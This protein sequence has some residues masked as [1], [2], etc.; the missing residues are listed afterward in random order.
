M[1]RAVV[2]RLDWNW[3]GRKSICRGDCLAYRSV[4]ANWK[5]AGFMLVMAELLLNY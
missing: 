5:V 2:F 1:S 4:K 3:H